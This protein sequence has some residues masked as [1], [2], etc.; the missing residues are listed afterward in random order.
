MNSTEAWVFQINVHCGEA[1]YFVIETLILTVDNIDN[2][3]M[4]FT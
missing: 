1:C 4:A 3:C 2:L